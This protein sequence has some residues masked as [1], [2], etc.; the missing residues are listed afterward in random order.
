MRSKLQNFFE[1]ILA[2]TNIAVS[3]RESDEV[4]CN[5]FVAR[6]SLF[7]NVLDYQH[8]TTFKIKK[9]PVFGVWRVFMR[10]Y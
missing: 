7:I 2:Y 4:F 5:L 1:R 10:L 6:Y 8:L 3:G 9:T